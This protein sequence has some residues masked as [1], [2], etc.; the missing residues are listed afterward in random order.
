MESSSWPF[1]S[2]NCSENYPK[3]KTKLGQQKWTE[4]FV[5]AKFSF[6]INQESFIVVINVNTVRKTIILNALFLKQIS[7][8]SNYNEQHYDYLRS[9]INL[10]DHSYFGNSIPFS[11]IDNELSNYS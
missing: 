2:H 8:Y 10:E 5:G 3:T 6:L 9:T 1:N 7:K 11:F 4:R